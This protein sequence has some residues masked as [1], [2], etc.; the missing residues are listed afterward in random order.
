MSEQS[1]TSSP[2][3]SN[4][5][6]PSSPDIQTLHLNAVSE[7]DKLE[8]A[9]LKVD[10]NKAFTCELPHQIFYGCKTDR[11]CTCIAHN[12]PAAAQLYSEAIEK[13]P[14]EPTLWCNRAYARMKLEEFGYALTDASTYPASG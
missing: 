7:E 8:A 9:R 6:S 13:N 3:L 1:A 4:S 11:I 14:L 5:T 10:A 12:F 2:S